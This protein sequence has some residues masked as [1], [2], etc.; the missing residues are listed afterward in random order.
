MSDAH[1]RAE[2]KRLPVAD[3]YWLSSIDRRDRQT[4]GRTDGQRA[5]LRRL[6]H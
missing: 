6:P 4:D 1:A 5:V 2:A 3:A